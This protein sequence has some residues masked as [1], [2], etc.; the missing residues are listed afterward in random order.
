MTREA[1]SRTFCGFGL[2][3]AVKPSRVSRQ[4]RLSAGN[5]DAAD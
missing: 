1:R 2:R 3:L 5:R 4:A